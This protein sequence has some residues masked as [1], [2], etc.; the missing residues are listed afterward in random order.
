MIQGH[1]RVNSPKH[2]QHTLFE[3]DSASIIVRISMPSSK[4]IASLVHLNSK[5]TIL[6]CEQARKD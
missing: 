5:K 6:E 2:E 1:P 3:E 4:G